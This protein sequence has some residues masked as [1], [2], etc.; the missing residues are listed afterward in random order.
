MVLYRHSYQSHKTNSY[1]NEKL[2]NNELDTILYYVSI[3]HSLDPIVEYQNK[4]YYV[5]QDV[6][7]SDL[8]GNFLNL[9]KITRVA[10]KNKDFADFSLYFPISRIVNFAD[11]KSEENFKTLL[12]DLYIL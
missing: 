12:N 10:Y 9:Q 3:V 6:L 11:Q 5:K 2:K 1:F 4:L 8:R 7:S